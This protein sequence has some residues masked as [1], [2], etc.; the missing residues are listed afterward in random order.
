MRVLN[1]YSIFL[2]KV[3]FKTLFYLHEVMLLKF[4]EFPYKYHKILHPIIVTYKRYDIL[5]AYIF[6]MCNLTLE[7]FR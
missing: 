4:I 6:K 2:W 5:L 1:R 7:T 3:N